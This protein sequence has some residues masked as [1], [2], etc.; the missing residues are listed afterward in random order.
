MGL[1][2][3]SASR[4]GQSEAIGASCTRQARPAA[5]GGC[6]DASLAT[7]AV[8]PSRRTENCATSASIR[9]WLRARSI[10]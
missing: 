8:A 3:A 2:A 5:G 9:A 4:A 10:D 6:S 1:L 7:V